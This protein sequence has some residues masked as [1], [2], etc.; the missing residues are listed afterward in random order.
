MI[1]FVKNPAIKVVGGLNFRRGEPYDPCAFIRGDDGKY[2]PM[3]EWEEGLIKVDAIGTGCIAIAR[4]VFELLEPPWFYNDY[5]KVFED[6]W[7]GEDMGFA[8]KCQA[9]GIQ[10]WVDTTITSPHLI[11]ALIDRESYSTFIEANNM[12]SIP[13]EAIRKEAYELPS[14]K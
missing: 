5:S 1:N 6:V 7:P 11:D 2:Y 4:E 12:G 10:Q 9:A 13:L 8:V 3:S 14:P